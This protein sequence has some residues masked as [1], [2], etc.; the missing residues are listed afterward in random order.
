MLLKD[1]QERAKKLGIDPDNKE[2]PELIHEMQQREG[3][4]PCFGHRLNNSYCQ[5]CCWAVDC[6]G[7]DSIQSWHTFEVIGEGQ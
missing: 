2:K 3:Y 6:L 5:N 4:A 7:N 1:I